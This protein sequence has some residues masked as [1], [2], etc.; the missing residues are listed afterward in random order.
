[1]KLKTKVAFMGVLCATV[2]IVINLVIS[3]PRAQVI[4]AD[5][6]SNNLLNLA[7]AYGK[8]V[9][10]RI[11]QN[12]NSM[13]LTEELQEL[14]QEVKI[15]GVDSCASY[16]ISSSNKVLYHPDE[17]LIG[18]DNQNQVAIDIGTQVNTGLNPDI[19]PSVV[20]YWEE[21]TEMIAGY[22]VL[23]SIGSIVMI[24]AEKQDAVSVS[25][26]LLRTNIAAAAISV[27]AALVFSLFFATL[28]VKPI[29]RVNKVI[30]QCSKLNFKAKCFSKKELRRKDEIG[31]ISRAME[32]LQ[33][34]LIEIIGKLSGV[35][36]DLVADA[37]NLGEMVGILENH[38]QETSKTATELLKIMKANQSSA[39]QIDQGVIGINDNAKNIDIQTQNGVQS[40]SKVIEDARKMK[41]STEAACN[42]T[43]EMYEVL[44]KDSQ[45]IMER[46]KEIERITQLTGSIVEIAEQTELLALNASIEAARAGEQG[47]G[48][49]VVATEISKLAQQ[50]NTLASGIMGTTM[51]V[52]Q[53][54]EEA[55][56][57]LERTIEFLE[58]SI[59]KD[60]KGFMEVCNVYL[61]NSQ[62]IDEDMRKIK[63]AVSILYS[64]TVDIKTGVDEISDSINDSTEGISNV[65]NQAKEILQM[66]S[67]VYRLSDQTQES[68]EDLSQIVDKFVIES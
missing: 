60:Y 68:A 31:D 21:D 35:S 9:E 3:I 12:G 53:V 38:S 56:E 7:K 66:V 36:G 2:A 25:Q 61:D 23:D 44:R 11:Q 57:C 18:T 37:E 28:L 26:I 24:V 42:K 30:A 49:A 15:D 32:H 29:R 62:E 54:S 67:N 22:Y 19:E 50:S 13:L 46:S 33:N 64:M 20:E 5:S 43:V 6:V 48:F 40:I 8:M 10:M 55:M 59:L 17:T 39:Y 58:G 1:M 65:A 63:E 51:N 16:F 14:F 27:V 34:V 52:R 41:Q 47:K 4:I 45:Y